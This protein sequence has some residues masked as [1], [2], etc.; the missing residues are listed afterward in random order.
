[1]PISFVHGQLHFRL[2]WKRQDERLTHLIWLCPE[3]DCKK[4]ITSIYQGTSRNLGI[5][6]LWLIYIDI[7]DATQLYAIKSFERYY[8]TG[9]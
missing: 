3:A 6:T 1:M 5:I 8:V 9:L 7:L 4:K 2:P